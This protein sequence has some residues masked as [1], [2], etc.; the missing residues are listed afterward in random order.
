MSR[1]HNI[2]GERIQFTPEE[3]TARDAEEALF[4]QK[5]ADYIANEKYKDDR[6]EAYGSIGDQLD[7]QYW[8]SVNGTTV[9]ADHIA[10]VKAAHPKPS[11]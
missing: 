2:D 8:D 1:F 11:N 4:A 9:W 7:M 10:A 6:R 5:Q 3:E